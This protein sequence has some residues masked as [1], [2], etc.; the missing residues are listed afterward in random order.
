MCV[1]RAERRQGSF[2][3]SSPTPAARCPPPPMRPPAAARGHV[4]AQADDPQTES[5]PKNKKLQI[6]K[7]QDTKITYQK[8][9]DP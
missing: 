5:P 2:Y 8:N 3:P 4:P 9:K 1:H 6:R 7:N